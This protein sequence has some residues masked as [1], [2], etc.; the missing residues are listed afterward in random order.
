MTLK[1]FLAII[2]SFLPSSFVLAH[3]DEGETGYHMMSD[4]M[5]GWFIFSGIFMILFLVLVVLGIIALISWLSNQN[6]K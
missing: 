4:M 1:T 2:L 6:R 5:G 3:T